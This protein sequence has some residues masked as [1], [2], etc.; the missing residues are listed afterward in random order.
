MQKTASHT[1]LES[2]EGEDMMI[3]FSFKKYI[4]N[5]LHIVLKK[6]VNIDQISFVPCLDAC[7]FHFLTYIIIIAR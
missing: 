3:E 2:H 1:N 6:I 7:F 4:F 5:K